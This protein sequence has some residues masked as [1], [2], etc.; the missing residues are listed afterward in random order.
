MTMK[1]TIY[2]GLILLY[3]IL[4]NAQVDMEF[5]DRKSYLGIEGGM[6]MPGTNLKDMTATNGLFAK[7]GYQIGFDYNYI[8]GYGLGIGFNV[9][10]DQFNFN[11]EEYFKI[12][13]AEEMTVKG[14]Y[15]ST[16]FGLNILANIPLVVVEKKFAINFF[17]EF[18]AGLRGF[19]A[20]A[21]DLYY[22]EIYNK[23]VEVSYR[24]RSNTMGF[25]GYSGGLQF[26]FN[27]RFG[28]NLSYNAL[29]KS[30]HSIKYSVRKFDAFNELY[31][32]ED[33]LNNYLD[34][35]GFQ[36]GIMFIFGKK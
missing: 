31:E 24:S 8:F 6:V 23:Y 33:Y 30:R 18:N 11:K 28:I 1:K 14:G 32:S 25:L 35:T 22:N 9:E 13:E 10:Y 27:N 2:T 17:G 4:L 26:I 21:I 16:K 34:H 5:W 19:N 12:T 20:P 7:N 36:I 15:S 3:S 29:L